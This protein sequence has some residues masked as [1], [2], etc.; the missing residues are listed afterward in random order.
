MTTTQP[1]QN[2]ARR[3]LVLLR[4]VPV[5]SP[6][7][8]LWA[9]TKLIIIFAVGLLLATNPGWV[10]LAATAGLVVVGIWLAH[11]PRSAL[12]AV[13]G[14]V[15]VMLALGSVFLTTSGGAPFIELG[16]VHV[17]LGGVLQFLQIT[18]LAIVLLMLGALLSW[19]TELCDIAPALV[20]LGRPLKWLRIPV[21]DW[22]AT[23]S[24]ALRS[25]PMMFDE[26]RLMHAARKLRPEPPLRTR[27]QRLGYRVRDFI[28]LI[29]TAIAMVFRRADEMGDAITARGGAGQIAV[30]RSGP[31]PRDWAALT[32]VVLVCAATLAVQFAV[33]GP[34]FP[35]PP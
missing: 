18:T 4:P 20:T 24:L 10:P 13:P 28:D 29:S 11:I 7:H 9:G 6:I 5:A 32:I 33:G 15:W 21:E 26:F 19:T 8:S 35:P 27:R 1:Q 31:G 3:P 22:A 12:P 34:A 16:S 17:G 14:P 23:L 25:F 2:P 30:G